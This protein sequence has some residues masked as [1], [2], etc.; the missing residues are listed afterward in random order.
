MSPHRCAICPPGTYASRESGCQACVNGTGTMY[1]GASDISEC[2]QTSCPACDGLDLRTCDAHHITESVCTPWQEVLPGGSTWAKDWFRSPKLVQIHT[3]QNSGARLTFSPT[4]SYM[5]VHKGEQISILL[6]PREDVKHGGSELLDPK[7]IVS[8]PYATLFFL[9]LLHIDD[10][11]VITVDG[12]VF[13][14]TTSNSQLLQ[15]GKLQD[16]N[17]S[18]VLECTVQDPQKVA[19]VQTDG[20]SSRWWVFTVPMQSSSVPSETRP[21]GV[22]EGS[23]AAMKDKIYFILSDDS[24]M[25]TMT[26]DP[27]DYNIQSIGFADR[28]VQRKWFRYYDQGVPQM[29]SSRIYSLQPNPALWGEGL[30]PNFDEPHTSQEFKLQDFDVLPSGRILVMSQSAQNGTSVLYE[31]QHIEKCPLFSTTKNVEVATSVTACICDNEYYRDVA[32]VENVCT[33]CTSCPNGQY[34]FSACNH[35]TDRICKECSVVCQVGEY[36][37]ASCSARSDVVCAACTS[38]SC[39]SDEYLTQGCTGTETDGVIGCTPC[40]SCEVGTYITA[41]GCDANGTRS[42]CS[43]CT[44]TCGI[45]EYVGSPCDGSTTYSTL[46]CQPCAPCPYGYFQNSTCTGI[47]RGAWGHCSR[48]QPGCGVGN[49][50]KDYSGCVG[51]SPFP[52][53]YNCESCAGL[54][55]NGSYPS[56]PCDGEGFGVPTCKECTCPAG[57]IVV[58]DDGVCDCKPCR[59]C[60]SKEYYSQDK[61]SACP[62]TT[63]VDDRCK[64]CDFN[65]SL[66]EYI[67]GEYCP[68]MHNS[69]D[70][71][72]CRNCTDEPTPC[73]DTTEYMDPTLCSGTIPACI[74]RTQCISGVTYGPTLAE[75]SSF[76]DTTCQDC[77]ICTSGQYQNTECSLTKDRH[78]LACTSCSAGKYQHSP[79]GKL[80]RDRKCYSCNACSIGTIEL[81]ACTTEYDTVCQTVIGKPSIP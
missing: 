47:T 13:L 29:Y 35:T 63:T 51:T 24:G 14:Y 59:D 81:S 23:L 78:C 58:V 25:A 8:P 16:V 52:V 17:P 42:A 66:G 31:Y 76:H 57:Q 80:E 55:P 2:E 73:A 65:C 77:T 49:Y 11:L 62:G 36:I 4:G 60:E 1:V 6:V 69:Q 39:P 45:G 44:L 38:L 53:Q 27:I 3:L 9:W 43:E 70:D 56:P 64:V 79:C 48:C 18:G 12:S 46:Q 40:K 10:L 67:S 68:D 41:I 28:W 33:I 71:L 21:I 61:N 72:H 26:L 34:E 32:D 37:Q 19:C 15:R 50:I 5:A 30:I 7:R 74:A 75:L 22:R 54:C 20:D